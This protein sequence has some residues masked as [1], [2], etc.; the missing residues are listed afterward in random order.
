MSVRPAHLR[1]GS[2]EPRRKID[3]ATDTAQSY[4]N[5]AEAGVA[6]RESGL[7]RKEIFITTKYSGSDGLDIKTSIHNS[8]KNVCSHSLVSHFGPP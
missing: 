8:L 1:S 6:I 3:A 4:R 5:E 7:E 2:E